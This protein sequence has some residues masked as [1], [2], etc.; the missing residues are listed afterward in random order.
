MEVGVVKPFLKWPG[1]KRW[2]VANYANLL[3]KNFNRYIGNYHLD[4]AE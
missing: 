3:P 4:S 1:G 2:F